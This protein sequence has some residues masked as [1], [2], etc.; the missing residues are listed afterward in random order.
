ALPFTMYFATAYNAVKPWELDR[1]PLWAYMYIHGTFLF[2]IASLLVWQTARW[3]RRVRVRE[4]QGQIVPVGL[5][6]L[7]LI[8]AIL[9]SVVIGARD[10]PVL[11]V[12]G[13]LTAW[14]MLLFLLPRQSPL[15]RAI[16]ALIALALIISVG[17][18]VVVLEGDIGRQNTVFK[19][20]LQVWFFLSIVG[21]VGLAWMLHTTG[22]W[23]VALRVVWQAGLAILFTIALLYPVLATQARFA[24]RF[25]R[26]ETPLTLDGM[27]YMRHA[28]HGEQGVWFRLESDYRLIRWLQEHIEGTPVIVEAHQFPSEYHWNGRISI[29]TGLPTLLGWNFHQRQQHS[30]SPLDMLVQT[31]ENNI[32]AFYSLGGS[33][34]IQAAWRLIQHYDVEYIVVGILERVA[35][36]DIQ[37]DLMAGT[38][39]AGHAAGLAKF[40]QMVAMKLLEVVYQA[41]GCLDTAVEDVVD[42]PAA[43]LVTDKVYRVLPGAS[44]AW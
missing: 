11:Q 20:Y 1:T 27:E 43:S 8:G 13:P 6:V 25:N 38:L 37:L 26:D 32:A 16:N 2:I 22:R 39:T 30:L 44:P 12:A 29:Y 33:E 35:Y 10:V 40:D 34:G 28:I 36:D 5:A 42:C 19:F 21:G 7:G 17:V 4:L 24:D 9:A 23:H 14:A 31:R 15:V 41:D 18:E 3:L